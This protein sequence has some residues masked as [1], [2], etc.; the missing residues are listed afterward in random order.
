[1]G[2]VVYFKKTQHDSLKGNQQVVAERGQRGPMALENVEDGGI[3][4]S[5]DAICIDLHASGAGEK[6]GACIG[7]SEFA[8]CESYES[9]LGHSFFY[10][11]VSAI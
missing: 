4:P 5:G 3:S 1:M 10:P 8:T 11:L 7:M 6:D 2:R 9:P